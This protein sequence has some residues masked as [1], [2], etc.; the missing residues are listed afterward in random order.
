[1]TAESAIA[2]NTAENQSAAAASDI[3]ATVAT[4]EIGVMPPCPAAD[5]PPEGAVE[6]IARL[7]EI[8]EH[9][10]DE[11]NML[12]PYQEK[13]E[14]M[15][16]EEHEQKLQQK[17][18][19]LTAY[20]KEH[21]LDT[22]DADVAQDIAELNYEGIFARIRKHESEAQAPVVTSAYHGISTGNVRY[23]GLLE[24]A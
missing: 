1:M 4:A 6:T 18:D 3:P 13:V 8:I 11:V 10:R 17:K 2:L 20:A 22:E 9:L 23:G 19:E 24:R 16:Q 7:T 14:R 21:G 15:E 12:R 5:R